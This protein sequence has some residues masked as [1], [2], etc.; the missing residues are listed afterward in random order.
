MKTE[1]KISS[2]L[3]RLVAILLLPLM[4]VCLMVIVIVTKWD[5]REKE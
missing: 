3:A 4:A 2:R 5:E 1:T